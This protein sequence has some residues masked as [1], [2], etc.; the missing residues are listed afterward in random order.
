M[1][2]ASYILKLMLIN[3]LFYLLYQTVFSIFYFSHKN[4]LGQ[5][6]VIR[7]FFQGISRLVFLSYLEYITLEAKEGRV[8]TSI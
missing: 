3:N 1:I 8:T 6:F 5:P 4:P 7:H 2:I